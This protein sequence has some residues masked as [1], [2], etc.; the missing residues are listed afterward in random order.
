MLYFAYYG[1]TDYD[2][3]TPGFDPSQYQQN[4]NFESSGIQYELADVGSSSDTGG[5]CYMDDGNE[6]NC[7]PVAIVFQGF[8]YAAETGSYTFYTP[9]TIDNE[10]MF[11]HGNLAYGTGDTWST[12]NA[13]YNALRAN[14]PYGFTGGSVA[15]TLNAGQILPITIIF[16]NSSPQS[17]LYIYIYTPDGTEYGGTGGFF[18]PQ[19]DANGAFQP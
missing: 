3:A 9:D 6:V 16:G 14:N 15:I 5:T 13:D 2:E 7:D 12:A 11:F 18:S 4:T 19:C 8:F 17:N 1:D 10:L